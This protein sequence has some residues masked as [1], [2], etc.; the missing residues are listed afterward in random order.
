[1]RTL[2]FSCIALAILLIT[3]SVFSQESGKV[4]IVRRGD[5]LWDLSSYYLH[6]PF[7]WPSIYEANETQIKDPH[8]IYPGQMFRIPPHLRR[9]G[10]LYFLKGERVSVRQII[11]AEPM[12][13]TQLA[14]KG[15][16]LTTEDIEVGYIVESERKG[17]ENITSPDTVYI[18][19]GEVDGVK[20]GDLFTIFRWG[21]KVKDPDTGE[22]LGRI[23]NVLGKLV[24]IE[25]V[26]N[27]SSA[28][29]VQSFDIIKNHDMIADYEAIEMPDFRQLIS[30]E[31]LLEGRIAAAKLDNRTIIPFHIVYINLGA[32]D[33]IGVGDYFEIFRK[34]VKVGD[35][36][37]KGKVELPEVKVGALQ[38]LATTNESS[39]CYI[40]DIYANMDIEEGETIRLVGRGP[41]AGEL[42]SLDFDIEIEE[43]EEEEEWEE[44][45]E[46]EGEIIEPE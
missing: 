40:T 12:V 4:H 42:E 9:R 2:A 37:P 30:P 10:M 19:L 29:I 23:V 28:E 33:G 16:Y 6:N 15:G 32:A 1:M 13:A 44:M 21:K 17:K 35:P 46:E 39:T 22:Y 24:V 41:E 5:T 45:E 7:L 31:A 38:V 43:M 25:T 27:S 8:W 20:P 34:G 3:V 36:G 14:Y 18:D 26:E 11:S